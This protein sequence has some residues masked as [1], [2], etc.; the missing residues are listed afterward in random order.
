MDYLKEQNFYS[1]LSEVVVRI[2]DECIKARNIK[3]HSIQARAKDPTSFAKK[4]AKPSDV[5]PSKPKYKNPLSDITDLAGVRVIT[6]FLGTLS[7]IDTII[8]EEFEILEKSNKGLELIEEDRFGYQSVHYLVKIRSIRSGLAEYSRFKSAV[9]EIQVR[10]I[11]QHAWAEIEHDI[12]YKSSDTIPTEIH[13]RFMALAGM[14][15]VADRE[16]QAIDEA[17]RQLNEKASQDVQKGKLAGVEITPRSI[18]EF[19]DK[20]L[21][22]DGRISEAAYDWLARLLKTIGFRDLN[23]VQTAISPYNDDQISRIGEGG[24]LGQI[25][26][27]ELMIEAAFGKEALLK[28]HPFRHYDWYKK[29]LDRVFSRLVEAGVPVGTFRLSAHNE[30]DHLGLTGKQA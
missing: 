19:L 30:P 29:R 21:G 13:R 17:D 23:E 14:L 5:D 8:N 28:H 26:R 4:A 7:D 25:S 27:F 16:F 11:L 24:R 9:T 22:P 10:T 1:A 3:I 2:L 15:E 20:N 12:Q 6:Q 18:K